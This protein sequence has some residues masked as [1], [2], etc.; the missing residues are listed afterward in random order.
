MAAHC[1]SE[2]RNDDPHGGGFVNSTVGLVLLTD[3]RGSTPTTCKRGRRCLPV[4]DGE[5]PQPS[6]V[7]R[8]DFW[9]PNIFCNF[10]RKITQKHNERKEIPMK[11]SLIVRHFL[12]IR[13][14]GGTLQVAITTLLLFFATLAT[15]GRRRTGDRLSLHFRGSMGA[16]ACS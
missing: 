3:R 7:A 2:G 15:A 4:R 1:N 8:D 14:T 5:A 12:P 6:Q 9:L 10:G 13:A 16:T 11:Q